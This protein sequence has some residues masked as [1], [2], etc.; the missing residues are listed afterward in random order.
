MDIL[1]LIKT[2][3]TMFFMISVS[4][5]V[6]QLWKSIVLSSI[7]FSLIGC[8]EE[9]EVKDCLDF[10][11]PNGYSN[12]GGNSFQGDD[13]ISI[14]TFSSDNKG[15]SASST[16]SHGSIESIQDGV[17]NQSGFEVRKYKQV[18][19]DNNDPR[20]NYLR[21]IYEGSVS[22][23]MTISLVALSDEEENR[24]IGKLFGCI[25]VLSKNNSAPTVVFSPD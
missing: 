7:A 20:F 9:D 3:I 2:N 10:S 16:D 8:Y 23:T 13:E 1:I 4:K 25:E 21:Y 11:F 6:R 19:N 15:F 17:F 18:V 22:D 14:L 24:I 12:I 5:G